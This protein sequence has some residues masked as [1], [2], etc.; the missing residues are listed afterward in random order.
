MAERC[1]PLRAQKK[2]LEAYDNSTLEQRGLCEEGFNSTSWP[3]GITVGYSSLFTPT[4]PMK[5]N[6]I[7]ALRIMRYCKRSDLFGVTR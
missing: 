3:Q 5:M 6:R 2:F 7:P 4:W 1:S